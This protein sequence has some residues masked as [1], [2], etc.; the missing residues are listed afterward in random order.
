MLEHFAEHQCF[1]GE[2]RKEPSH[3]GRVVCGFLMGS[4]P[5]V[6][7]S[8]WALWK[9]SALLLTLYLSLLG[10]LLV[11]TV[12]KVSW[13]ETGHNVGNDYNSAPGD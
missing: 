9:L 10:V 11:L 12:L 6:F 5:L 3:N 13:D 2:A 1:P 7:G 8:L 4:L